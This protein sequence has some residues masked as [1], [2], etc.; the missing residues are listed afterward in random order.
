MFG[1]IVLL[2]NLPTYPAILPGFPATLLD[3]LLSTIDLKLFPRYHWEQ[4]IN[5]PLLYLTV[6]VS[7]FF[8]LGDAKMP[9]IS[10]ILK[11]RSLRLLMASLTSLL[12]VCGDNMYL[13]PLPGKFATILYA[14]CPFINARTVVCLTIYTCLLPHF[15][16]YSE[17]VS[18]GINN[19][20]PLD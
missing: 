14:L 9:R 1:V 10:P 2:G 11:L 20:V 18:D 6:S 13:R 17:T 19:I 5:D 4:N 12:T 3:S 7:I 8:K 15:Y 16:N